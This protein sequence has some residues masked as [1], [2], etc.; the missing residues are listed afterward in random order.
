MTELSLT[1]HPKAQWRDATSAQRRAWASQVFIRHPRLSRAIET[2][3]DRAARCQETGRGDGIFIRGAP[4]TGKTRLLRYLSQRFRVSPGEEPDDRTLRPLISLR[5][6]DPCTRKRVIVEVLRAI[7][8]QDPDAGSY[9]ESMARAKVLIREC[10]VQVVTVDDL[11]DVPA[12]RTQRGILDIG[13]CFRDLIDDTKALYVFCGTKDAQVVIDGDTQ[14]RRRVP[15][16]LALEYFDLEARERRPE[17]KRLMVE[18]D[19]WLPLAEESCITASPSM[20]RMFFASGGI[21][22]YMIELLDLAWP[23]AIAEGRESI[24]DEDLRRAYESLFGEASTLNPF[25]TSGP[26]RP[27]TQPGEVFHGWR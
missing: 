2:I 12:R 24:N 26:H 11:Q 21:V 9:H 8:V 18:L 23:L 20:E 25:S 16:R 10:Q 19:R 17:F 5:V 7:G 14:L 3:S 27:L 1:P 15:C 4:G 6:P 22:Q 13:L